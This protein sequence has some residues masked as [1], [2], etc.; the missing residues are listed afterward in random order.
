MSEVLSPFSPKNEYQL[1]WN[2]N[3]SVEMKKRDF[4]DNQ[5]KVLERLGEIGCNTFSISQTV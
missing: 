3:G 2:K 5:K 1:I 4:S